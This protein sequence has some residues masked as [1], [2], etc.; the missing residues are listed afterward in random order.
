MEVDPELCREDNIHNNNSF[1]HGM[2]GWFKN[3]EST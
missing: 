1:I 2:Q 3:L